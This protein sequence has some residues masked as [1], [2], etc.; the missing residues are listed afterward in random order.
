VPKCVGIDE[1]PDPRQKGGQLER[2]TAPAN[3][4]GRRHERDDADGDKHRDR[5]REDDGERVSKRPGDGD[6]DERDYDDSTRVPP[7]PAP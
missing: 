1:A 5:E 6:D 7:V 4:S 2:N 3:H